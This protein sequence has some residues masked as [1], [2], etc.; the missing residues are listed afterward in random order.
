MQMHTETACSN[1]AQLD[2]VRAVRA[3]HLSLLHINAGEKMGFDCLDNAGL[4]RAL[5]ECLA[6]AGHVA[7]SGETA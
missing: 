2:R 4:K 5:T 1:L 6:Q 7:F 3:I